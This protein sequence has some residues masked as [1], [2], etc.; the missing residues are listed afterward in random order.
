MER[1]ALSITSLVAAIG[2]F[3]CGG[4]AR[5]NAA[6][7]GIAWKSCSDPLLQPFHAQCGFLSVPLDYAKPHGE[8]I[9]LAVSRI[10]HTSSAKHYQG[11]ILTNPGGP[12]GPGIDLNT[13][14]IPA[15]QQE[16]YKAA[17]ADYDWIGFDPRGVGSS[18]PALSCDPHYW[19]PDRPSYIASTPALTNFW[20]EKSRSYAQACGNASPLQSALLRNM[21]T[22]D[23]AMDMDRIREALGQRQITYYGFSWGTYLGQVYSTMFPSRVRRLILDSIVNPTRVGYDAFNL[24]QDRPVNRD[25]D[26]FFGWLAK[27]NRVYHLGTTESAVQK[28][29]FS[30]EAQLA[31]KP[32]GGVVGPDEWSDIYIL[33]AITNFSWPHYGQVFSDWVHKHDTATA[34]ELINLYRN[35]DTPGSDNWYAAYLAVECTDSRWPLNWGQWNSDVS[36]IYKSA[37]FGAWA[38][39]WINAPCIFWPARSSPLFT[40]NGSR[41]KS[42][43]LIDETLDAATP[44]PGSLVVRNLFPHSVLLAEPG[45]TNHA[46]SL[47]GDRCVDGTIAAYLTTGALPPRKS[48]P[49][50]D[51]TCAPI[52][53]PPP[54]V[55]RAQSAP[56]PETLQRMLI[57]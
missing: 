45:G 15:L 1:T 32:A 39:A 25:E 49:G 17:A 36:T 50:P 18:R 19:G 31:S 14:L 16:G 11:V 8:Q 10:E 35:V 29:F 9:Q 54:S 7:R 41:I 44:Y 24:D 23:I 55:N 46:D 37:P 40:V 4:A 22:R 42:A 52:P 26:M 6:T 48:G 13:F 27:Y 5:A 57:R 34:N 2:I 30:T 20:L 51:K 47:S 12:G 53:P 3:F 56:A 28:R 33:P 21:T 43:L 38:N